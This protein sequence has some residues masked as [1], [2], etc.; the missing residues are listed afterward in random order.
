MTVDEDF[1]GKIAVIGMAG[2]FPG[3]ADIAEFLAN[4]RGGVESIRRLTEEEL[5]AAGTSAETLR[6]P[7]FVPAAAPLA[8]IDQFDAAFFGMSPRDAAVFDPQH[9]VLLE[10]A[11]EVFESAGYVSSEIEGNVAVFASCGLSE[12]MF[13]NVMANAQVAESV[14]EWLVRHTG[15][16]TNF[17]A[18]RISYELN[19]VGP[20]MNVQTACSSTLVALHLACQSLLAGECDLAI[21]GGAVIAPVQHKGYHYKEGEILS[22]DGHC[23]PF[24]A[25]SAGTVISSAAGCV[26][27]KPL[28]HAMEDGDTVLA[29]IRGSAI[30]NDGNDK[31]GYLAPSV[32][33]QARVVAEALAVADVDPRDVSYIEAHG[34]GTL[35]G[36]PI[37]IGGLTQAYRQSTDD[38]QFCAIGSLKSNIGHTGEAAGIAGFI[39]TVLS[40]HHGELFPSLHYKSPNPQADFPSS[41]FY[42][43]AT[44]APW[45]VPA[46][47]RRIAGITG[48]GAGGTNAHVLVEEGP[49]RAASGPSTR[50]AQ[51]LAI[52]A[53]NNAS[54]GAAALR[55]A[56]HLRD[57]PQINLADVAHTLAVG[58]T[59]FRA[60]RVVAARTALEAAELL[61][62]TDAK[63]RVEQLHTGSKPSI[64]FMMPGGGAQYA[65]MGRDLYDEEPVYRAAIDECCRLVNPGLGLDLRTLMYPTGDLDEASRRLERPSVALPALFATEYAVAKLLESWGITPAA[66]IGHSAGEYVVACLSGVISLADGLAMVA[67]RGRLFETLPEGGMLSVSLPAE[68][69]REL[70]PQGLSIAADN[71]PELCVVSG[72]VD[73]LDEMEKILIDADAESVRV[74]IDVAAHSSML[75]PILAEFGAFCRTIRFNAPTIPYVSNLTGT[76]ATAADVTNPDYWVRHLREMVRFSDGIAAVL[77]GENRTL[78]EVGPGRTLCSFARLADTK[79]VAVTPSLRH[80]REVCSDVD[81][82]LTAFGRAWCSGADVDLTALQPD[83]QRNRISLPTYAFDRQRYWVDPDPLDPKARTTSGPLRKRDD[84]SEWFAVPSWHRAPITHVDRDAVG[85][86]MVIHRDGAL[87]DAVLAQLAAEGE[88]VVSVELSQGFNR[89]GPSRYEVRADDFGSWMTLIEALKISEGLPSRIIHLSALGPKRRLPLPAKR[90][91]AKELHTTIRRDQASLLFLAKALSL[92]AHPLR[93]VVVTQGVHGV[94][95][96]A[97]SRPELALLH[98]VCRVISRELPNATSLAVDIDEPTSSAEVTAMAR[99][100]VDEVRASTTDTVAYRRG[101]RW[102]REFTEVTLPPAES[103]PWVDRGVYLVTGG[104]GGIGLSVAAHIAATTRNATLVLI[105][106]SAFPVSESWPEL[107]ADVRTDPQLRR[108]IETLQTMQDNGATVVTAAADVTDEAVLARLVADVRGSYG[109]VNGVIHSAGVLDDNLLALREPTVGSPVVDV[110]VRGALALEAVLA[111]DPPELTVLFSSVSS[112]L[113]LPGQADYTAAN[114]FLDA[115][116]AHRNSVGGTRT[117]VVNWNAWQ[118]VGMAV[119]AARTQTGPELPAADSAALI[120]SV[121]DDGQVVAATTTFSRARHWLLDEHVVRNGDALIPGTGFIELIRS[122]GVAAYGVVPMEIS[123]VI[124]QAPFVVAPQERRVLHLRLDRSNDTITLFSDDPDSPHVTATVRPL[125]DAAPL[126]HD[127]VAL[128][129]ECKQFSERFDGY[130]AQPFMQFGPRWGNLFGVDYGNA[131]ALIHTQMPEAFVGEIESL[132]LHPAMLDMATGSAQAL[133]PGFDPATSF[134]VPFGYG[135]LR[136]WRPLPSSATSV[137]RLRPGGAAD[138]AVFDISICDEQGLEAVAIDSF[139]MR[140]V[141]HDAAIAARRDNPADTLPVIESAVAAALRQGILPA[142]GV[143]ALDRLLAVDLGPQVVASSVDIHRWAAQVDQQSSSGG[144]ALSG[145]AGEGGPQFQRPNLAVEYV[146][147]EG[148]LERRIAAIWRE[149]LGLELVGR[150]DDFFELGGQSL[151]AIRLMTRLQREF[152]VRLQLSDIFELQTLAALAGAIAERNPAAAAEDAA[153]A[154][155]PAAPIVAGPWK[156]LV[157][158]SA[159]GSGTPLFV[160]HG[161]GGNVLFL[162]SLARALRDIRPVY[163]LQAI[164]I[165][166]AHQPDPNVEAMADRYVAEIVAAHPGP[167]LLGGYSG[168]GPIALEMTNRLQALGKE[169]RHVLLFDSEPGYVVPRTQ[170]GMWKNLLRNLPRTG[171]MIMRPFLKEKIIRAYHKVIPERA[172]VVERRNAQMREFGQQIEG[173]VN[174]TEHFTRVVGQFHPGTYNVDATL[175][176]ADISWPT[177]PLDYGWKR[178]ITGEFHARIVSGDHWTMFDPE[179]AEKL[180]RKVRE[181]LDGM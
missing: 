167:Y 144:G 112:L 66:M 84:V 78:I 115:Y 21:A 103:S 172:E 135:N 95:A 100:L 50:P 22:P 28:A 108:R 4:L 158:V 132:W 2:R 52:S 8:D 12:Y 129:D 148:Q 154:I 145:E 130:S 136:V 180:G 179:I 16:D 25:Q 173:Y 155:D 1:E 111:D 30:N 49:Q 113:G 127:L 59:R 165:D 67:L 116:A 56:Q 150:H 117:V 9:R 134:F 33:G 96:E 13:K 68:R 151:I 143:D 97:P 161:A 152:G 39:K 61:E 85:S 139:T 128:A 65:S 60:R 119:E 35:I 149:L 26:L 53:K 48:L 40:L 124:F 73:L 88:R 70:M 105:G 83:E 138:V 174:L 44:H 92:Q 176:K 137:V 14:G 31:V 131:V 80:P 55:L 77:T 140:R 109:R 118:E 72:P 94:G 98:G 54:L 17:L 27:L 43:S 156:S 147:P 82:A 120:D 163:G 157:Q 89:V 104:L 178:H 106:R 146:E 164:G 79:P 5:L 87:A 3:A 51:L 41:P 91:A 81:F 162:W 23:R 114:A 159:S 168:G 64:V 177:M 75:E 76:W 142:E 90:D 121:T 74:H 6:D 175:L 47:K 122:I 15:N 133:I 29:V 107:L 38:V 110:K 69:A 63:S 93:I 18:T 32:S 58:R 45:T 20:S 46:G 181:V 169:V 10:C 86:T 125:A 37:E 101:Q 7:S 153:A 166:A 160:A 99:R 102:E 170:G 34:T 171:P 24:D 36:D 62:S 71:A 11:W 19:L 126:S 141:T 57:N 123:D 42:V